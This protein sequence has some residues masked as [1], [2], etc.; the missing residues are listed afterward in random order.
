M[1]DTDHL[2]DYER[3]AVIGIV[4]SLL[5]LLGIAFV[6]SFFSEPECGVIVDLYHSAWYHAPIRSEDGDIHDL[7]VEQVEDYYELKIGDRVCGDYVWGSLLL[8]EEMQP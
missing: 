1:F 3:S 7:R 2:W 6:S 5:I 4:I 8:S